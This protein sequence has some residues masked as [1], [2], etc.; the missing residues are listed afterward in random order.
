MRLFIEPVEFEWDEGNRDKN[1]KHGVTNQE[2][3]E[4]FRDKKKRLFKDHVHSQSEE[5]YRIIGKT[6]TDRLLFI[7]FTLR[8]T[9]VRIISARVINKKEAYLYEK[10]TNTTKL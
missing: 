6:K 9:K 3:E 1:V 4:A 7:V 8:K 5:R 2:A 10:E